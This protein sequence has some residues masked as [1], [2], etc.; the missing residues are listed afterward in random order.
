MKK[1]TGK[2]KKKYIKK[3]QSAEAHSYALDPTALCL[4]LNLLLVEKINDV[5]TFCD[6]FDCLLCLLF[7]LVPREIGNKLLERIFGG[8]S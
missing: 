4:D 1:L 2:A 5:T 8:R 6:V 3:H 7:V